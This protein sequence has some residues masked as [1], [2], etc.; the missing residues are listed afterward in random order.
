DALPIFVGGQALKARGAIGIGGDLI[1]LR[2]QRQRHG[3][4]DI[5]V[6]IDKG[7]F[8]HELPFWFG[9]M[10]VRRHQEMLAMLASDN[11]ALNK[12]RPR[13]L[14]PERDCGG[15][16]ARHRDPPNTGASRG[17]DPRVAWARH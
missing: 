2:F 16:V 8:W 13:A 15:G 5:A 3:G 4:E 6:V 11:Y 17:L 7:D 12:A 10:P 14:Q 1:A 9:H